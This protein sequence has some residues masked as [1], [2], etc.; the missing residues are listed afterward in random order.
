MYATWW[1]PVPTIKHEILIGCGNNKA[2]KIVKISEVQLEM[3]GRKKKGNTYVIVETS[4]L[5]F[6]ESPGVDKLSTSVVVNPIVEI[7]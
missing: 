3:M 5:S 2:S 1:L 7:R 4:W 6:E